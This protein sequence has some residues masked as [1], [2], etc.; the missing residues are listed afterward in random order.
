[1]A[2]FVNSS[3]R[4]LFL[5]NQTLHIWLPHQAMRYTRS[6]GFLS[7]NFDDLEALE[8]IGLFDPARA[9]SVMWLMSIQASLVKGM[10]VVARE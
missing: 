9:T 10:I 8:I 6:F 1:M 5:G 7:Q 4:L 2:K 3:T